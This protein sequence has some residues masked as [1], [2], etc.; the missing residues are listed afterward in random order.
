MQSVCTVFLIFF[1]GSNYRKFVTF[2][3]KKYT[4]TLDALNKMHIYNKCHIYN[5]SRLN[6]MFFLISS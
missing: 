1:T 6:S 4:H 2:D 5:A 3:K